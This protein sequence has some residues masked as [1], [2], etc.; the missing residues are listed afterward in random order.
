V[1]KL[2]GKKVAVI[3]VC[4]DADPEMAESTMEPF[5]RTV[6]FQSELLEWGGALAV[7]AVSG[8]G[9]AQKNKQA[10]KQAHQLGHKMGQS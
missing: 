5:R 9:E 3:A 1:P 7:P 10:L 4:G 8:K 2:R 6:Q